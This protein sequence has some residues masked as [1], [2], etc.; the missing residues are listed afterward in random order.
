MLGHYLVTQTVF[1]VQQQ[2]IWENVIRK[3]KEHMTWW[4]SFP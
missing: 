4:T 1:V 2:C 3:N